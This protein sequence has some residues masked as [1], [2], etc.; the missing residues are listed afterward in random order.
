V[1]CRILQAREER[2]TDRILSRAAAATVRILKARALYAS[3]RKVQEES[4]NWRSELSV[5]L[6]ARIR[7]LNERLKDPRRG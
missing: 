4:C 1:P 7:C 6:L 3:L 5:A 2:L